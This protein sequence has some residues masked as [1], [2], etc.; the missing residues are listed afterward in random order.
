MKHRNPKSNTYYWRAVRRLA[1]RKG[2]S[3]SK[4]RKLDWEK[5]ANAERKRRAEAR[6]LSHGGGRTKPVTKA[7]KVP[8]VISKPVRKGIPRKSKQVVPSR[9]PPVPTRG[10]KPKL[11]LTEYDRITMQDE[12]EFEE[13]E[14][15]QEE[16]EYEWQ[17]D[18]EELNDLDDLEGFMEDF[19][20]E[21]SDKYKEPA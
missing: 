1:E 8:S 7:G 12:E 18:W 15:W 19:E 6:I 3:I 10:H 13:S 5:E 20:Y 4:A 11:E 17:H 21:D 2:I 14:D 16:W 9:R